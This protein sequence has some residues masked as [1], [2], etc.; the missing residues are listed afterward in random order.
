[1]QR[2]NE[3]TSVEVQENQPLHFIVSQSELEEIPKKQKKKMSR[4]G[5]MMTRNVKIM[6]IRQVPIYLH[7]SALMVF[8]IATFA[9]MKTY[10]FYESVLGA[11]IYVVSIF[12]H[13]FSHATMYLY[14]GYSVQRMII[15]GGG[16]MTIINKEDL[17][18]LNLKHEIVICA[19]GPIV[20]AIILGLCCLGYLS[21]NPSYILTS[22]I[23]YNLSLLGFNLIPY[24]TSDGC[25]IFYGAVHLTLRKF[26]YIYPQTSGCI[27]LIVAFPITAICVIFIIK[28]YKNYFVGALFGLLDI[29]SIAIIAGLCKGRSRMAHKV[30]Q[31]KIKGTLTNYIGGYLS[32]QIENPTFNVMMSGAKDYD[33]MIIDNQ[34]N[35]LENFTVS[36]SDNGDQVILTSR[37]C[38]FFGCDFWEIKILNQVMNKNNVQLKMILYNLLLLHPENIPLSQNVSPKDINFNKSSIYLSMSNYFD[39]SSLSSTTDD[40]HVSIHDL[41]IKIKWNEEFRIILR[42]D[43]IN[44]K[45]NNWKICDVTIGI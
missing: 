23:T 14:Y 27:T 17:F 6:T 28:D 45:E 19:A 31:T 20:T 44:T 42:C 34:I 13:E 18:R 7:W 1:M 12:F 39:A 21:K 40:E 9:S 5:K 24:F 25:N 2:T 38:R 37:K 36:N 8:L 11:L 29:L 16:G 3:D 30:E 10:S 33:E 4:F 15:H 35:I 22:A 32:Q 26:Y 41:I 43:D